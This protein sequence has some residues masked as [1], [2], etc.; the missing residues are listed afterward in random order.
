MT[1][2]PNANG[3]TGMSIRPAVR[4]RIRAEAVLA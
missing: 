4:H 2:A 3:L 1:L